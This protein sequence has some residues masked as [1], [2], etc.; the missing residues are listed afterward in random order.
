L[1]LVRSLMPLEADHDEE[2]AIVA[3]VKQHLQF[4]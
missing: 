2:A 3:A 4:G 1:D